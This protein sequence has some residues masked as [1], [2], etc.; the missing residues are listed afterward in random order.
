MKNNILKYAVITAL[1]INAATLIFFWVKRPP[2]GDK[3]P[4]P[5]FEIIT[6]ELQLN[7]DQQALFKI[8]REQHHH[9]HDSLL[10]II[11]QKRRVLYAQKPVSIDSTIQAIGL[12]QEQIELITYEHFDNVRKICTPEQQTTLDTLLVG[13][14]QHVLMPKGNRPPPPRKE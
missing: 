1:L 11:A 9:S 2:H 5:P 4:K 10:Q 6:Q 8:L 13:T 12:L 7:S 3:P 14:V